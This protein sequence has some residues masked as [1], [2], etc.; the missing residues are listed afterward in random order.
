VK[1][2]SGRPET[3][4]PYGRLIGHLR[5]I[6]IQHD[7]KDDKGVRTK[8]LARRTQLGALVVRSR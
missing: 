6:L 4:W 7:Q 8:P 3:T 1:G 2:T 5:T